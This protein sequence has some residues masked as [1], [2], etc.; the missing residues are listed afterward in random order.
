MSDSEQR[1]IARAL[2]RA[3]SATLYKRVI[4]A[5]ECVEAAEAEPS[6]LHKRWLREA[7]KALTQAHLETALRSIVDPAEDK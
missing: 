4:W 3:E 6:R 7:D 5:N 2:S 1:P